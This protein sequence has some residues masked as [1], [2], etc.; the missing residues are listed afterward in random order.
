VYW[1]EAS[2]GLCIN[3]KQKASG[4]ENLEPGAKKKDHGCGPEGVNWPS[5]KKGHQPAGQ[6]RGLIP[7]AAKKKKNT[8]DKK[9]KKG[10]GN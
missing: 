6:G 8:V 2:Y 9:N 7:R 4:A 1:S 10:G 5:G 3:Q